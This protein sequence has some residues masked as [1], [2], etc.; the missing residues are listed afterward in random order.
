MGQT[1]IISCD[2]FN[3]NLYVKS[4]DCIGKLRGKNYHG[5]DKVVK[6]LSSGLRDVLDKK[7][8][9]VRAWRKIDLQSRQV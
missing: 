4:K 3:L 2:N 8:L 5:N 6:V 7:M 9:Q 1:P